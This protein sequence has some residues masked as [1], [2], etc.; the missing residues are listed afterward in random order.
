MK[1]LIL[2]LLSAVLLS[3]SW[4]TY[5]IPFFIF[6]A[7]VPLLVAEHEIT[8][9]SNIKRKSLAVFGLAYLVL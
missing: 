4:P 7:L 9:F 1:Y 3:V 8:K 6:F 5:G 2:A